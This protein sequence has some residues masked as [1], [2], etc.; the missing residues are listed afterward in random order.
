[1]VTFTVHAQ[2][3]LVVLRLQAGVQSCLRHCR[4]YTYYIQQTPSSMS[5]AVVWCAV[6]QVVSAYAHLS[7][8]QWHLQQLLFQLASFAAHLCECERLPLAQHPGHP[9]Y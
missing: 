2:Y 9:M 3:S 1:M 4:V 7:R 6:L 8:L 5:C